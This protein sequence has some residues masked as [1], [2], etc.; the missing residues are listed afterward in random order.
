RAFEA[1]VVVCNLDGSAAIA[2]GAGDNDDSHN[3][4]ESDIWRALVLG[5]RDYVRKCGFTQ[6][7]VGLSG[8]IDS[9]LTAAI[10][11]E[12]IGPDHLTGVLMPSP[13]S[14]PASITAESDLAAPLGLGPL[15]WPSKRVMRALEA[16]HGRASEGVPP[17]SAGG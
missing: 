3:S 7:V 10:A 11:A 15:P 9:A 13:S 12:A 14:A 2:T 16:T 1:D 6:A 5:T 4:S 17:R 8:G